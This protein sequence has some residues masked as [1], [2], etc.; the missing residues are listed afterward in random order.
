PTH[1]A[2]AA[3]GA[4][5]RPAGANRATAAATSCRESAGA[6]RTRVADARTRPRRHRAARPSFRESD[7]PADATSTP[8]VSARKRA[9]LAAGPLHSL[10]QRG[11]VLRDEDVLE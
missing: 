1:A 11:L 5:R 8:R 9:G 2:G 3:R 4:Q 7:V 6:S 10:R